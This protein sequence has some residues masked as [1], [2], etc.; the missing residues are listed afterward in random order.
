M[1]VRG[2]K[3]NPTER[4]SITRCLEG[5]AVCVGDLGLLFIEDEKNLP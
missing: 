2:P 1:G 3:E 4:I 5:W